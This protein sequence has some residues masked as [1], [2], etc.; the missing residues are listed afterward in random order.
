MGEYQ[1]EIAIE[2]LAHLRSLDGISAKIACTL[3]LIEKRLAICKTVFG[4]DVISDNEEEDDP[5]TT[6]LRYIIWMRAVEASQ[7][8]VAQAEEETR[9]RPGCLP[10][11]HKACELMG[12]AYDLRWAVMEGIS[13]YAAD[14]E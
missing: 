13:F 7:L 8:L 14:E 6:K 12:L 11:D 9:S 4:R 10:L 1:L 2:A 5:S 3:D